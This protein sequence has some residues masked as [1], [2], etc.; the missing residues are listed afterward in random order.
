MKKKLL[1]MVGLV[2]L[3]CGCDSDMEIKPGSA[4]DGKYATQTRTSSLE[5]SIFMNKQITVF[6]NQITARMS[7]CKNMMQGFNADNELTLANQSLNIM[8]D[9]LEEVTI[10]YPSVEG[11]DDRETTILAMETAI[12]HMKGYVAALENNEDVSGYIKDFENDFSQL[13]GLAS[14]YYQ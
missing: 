1:L 12:D 14:L 13:T 7:I 8:Q 10:T 2:F 4:S 11:E 9:A 5:Y 3:L 6:T